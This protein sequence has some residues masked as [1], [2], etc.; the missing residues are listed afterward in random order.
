[1]HEVIM[2]GENAQCDFCLSWEARYRLRTA[3]AG[4]WLACIACL[5]LIKARRVAELSDR[6]WHKFSHTAKS[7]PDSRKPLQAEFR[8]AYDRFF[9]TW[10]GTVEELPKRHLKYK[11]HDAGRN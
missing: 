10:T 4:S 3:N 5:Y 11:T 7:H 6:A 2:T 9:E 8:R 1:M